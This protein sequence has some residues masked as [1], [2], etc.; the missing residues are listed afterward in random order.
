MPSTQYKSIVEMFSGCPFDNTYAHTLEAMPFQNKLNWLENNC[1]YDRDR[2]RFEKQMK[3]KIDT[4]TNTGSIRLECEHASAMYYNYAYL[5]NLSGGGSWFCFIT[6]CRYI[7]EAQSPQQF[8]NMGIYEFDIEIDLI[9]SN[10]LSPTQLKPCMVARQHSETDN[11]GDNIVAE[12]VALLEEVYNDGGYKSLNPTTYGDATCILMY[13]M[14]ENQTTGHLVDG[15]FS[16]AKVHIFSTDAQGL[17]EAQSVINDAATA[18]KPEIILAIAM[19]KY[20]YIQVANVGSHLI[21][22]DT[23]NVHPTIVNI[24]N[25][26][27]NETIDGYT[28]KNKKLYTY[29]YN[30]CNVVNCKGNDMNLRYEFWGAN[31][32]GALELQYYCTRGLPL[33]MQVRP[34]DYKNNTTGSGTNAISPEVFLESTGF[35]LG[36]WSQE[37]Y[38]IWKAQNQA[39]IIG[40]V[41]KSAISLGAAAKNPIALPFAVTSTINSVVDIASK[42]YQASIV[43]DRFSG[44]LSGSSINFNSHVEGFFYVRKSIPYDSAKTVDDF[45]TRFGYAQVRLMQPNTS[46]RPY[47]TFLQTS[48]DCYVAGIE[49]G[50]YNGMTNSKQVAQINSILKKGITFWSRSITKN[51]IFKYDELDN[52]PS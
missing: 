5:N 49:A 20:S 16:A 28:P 9:M 11:I 2:D 42:E 17:E 21:M 10:L 52:S 30:Y 13:V 1:K 32:S 39:N 50:A 47:Y 6:G 45:F 8:D 26:T 43:A 44:T 15:V 22:G 24:P 37:S 27:G 19:S 33:T 7:N 12:P 4:A 34:I 18:G 41:A 40:T 23:Q 35:P 48:D 3:I 25:I 51:N 31:Q 36:T 38:E 14:E 29:P 46:A